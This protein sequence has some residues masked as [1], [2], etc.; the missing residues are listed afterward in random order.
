M[1]AVQSDYVWVY[2]THGQVDE[3]KAMVRQLLEERL[4]ACAN[5]NDGMTAMYWWDGA[6]Q[7]DSECFIIAKTRRDLFEQLTD[8][9]NALHP[10]EVPC[11]IALPIQGG[12]EP[13]LSWLEKETR[14]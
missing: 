1:S 7:E 10:Y 11:V 4:I 12:H 5:I 14:G 13:Y 9:V 2:M 8:R 3:A 6:V